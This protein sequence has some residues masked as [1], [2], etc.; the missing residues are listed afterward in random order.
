MD[1]EDTFG[2]I[3]CALTTCF[4]LPQLSPF[5]QVCKGK[6]NFEETP[7]YFM[8]IS[9]INCFLWMIYGEE[10]FS[11]QVK[12]TNLIASFIC[13]IAMIIY[14]SYEIKK[15][16]LDSILNFLI[17]FMASWAAYKYLVIEV[18]DDRVMGK[19]CFCS[20]LLIYS[21]FSYI[22]YRVINEKNYMLINFHYTS[23]YF[24]SCMIWLSFGIVTKDLY[25]VCPHSIGIIISL[26][27][28]SLYINYE[29]KYPSIDSK[30]PITGEIE[31]LNEENKKEISETKVEQTIELSDKGKPVKIVTKLNKN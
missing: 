25:V 6:L 17:I 26:V 9:Y 28:I 4:F 20:S 22:I 18:D 10:I 27:Q 1:L 24:V 14:L 16:V 3:G 7:G 13:L 23:I 11:D 12:I 30:D 2:W 31:E 19:L 8:S 21:Y 5:C 29:K 15:Y